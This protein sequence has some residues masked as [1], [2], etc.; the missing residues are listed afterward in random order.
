MGVKEN[1]K[2]EKRAILYSEQVNRGC[3]AHF[4]SKERVRSFL[5]PTVMKYFIEIGKMR[6]AGAPLVLT[7]DGWFSKVQRKSYLGII[8][9][10]V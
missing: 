3:A 10:T 4:P 8:G 7:V 5:L 1:S 2:E 6:I 9:F